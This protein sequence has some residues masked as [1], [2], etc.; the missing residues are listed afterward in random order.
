MSDQNEYRIR[1]NVGSERTE[2][3][4]DKEDTCVLTVFSKSIVCV[5]YVCTVVRN[6]MEKNGLVKMYFTRLV[7]FNIVN[8]LLH[9]SFFHTNNNTHIF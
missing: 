9:V 6:E 3:S 5:L 8:L 1:T 7:Y 4:H 2:R